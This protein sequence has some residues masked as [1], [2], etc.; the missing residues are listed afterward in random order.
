MID[1]IIL[2]K[3]NSPDGI[4]KY[5]QK[6]QKNNSNAGKVQDGILL[7]FFLSL[8]LLFLLLFPLTFS[9]PPSLLLLLYPFFCLHFLPFL[10][11]LALSN[12]L[13][14]PLSCSLLSSSPL[15]SLVVLTL[16]CYSPSLHL[17]SSLFASSFLLFSLQ[18]I[19]TSLHSFLLFF[20][21]PISI[22]LESRS[23]LFTLLTS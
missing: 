20:S 1:T 5:K 17:S 23:T 4:N 10:L 16:F 18:S 19:L 15:P 9:L 21:P 3:V 14:F 2:P 8:S 6:E 22:L 12:L 7:L 13:L 11:A